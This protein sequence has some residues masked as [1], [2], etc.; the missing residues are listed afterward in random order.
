MDDFEKQLRHIE[1]R[2]DR[3]AG[4]GEINKKEF[5]RANR[6]ASREIVVATRSNLK[7]YKED[8]TIHFEDRDDIV[9][10]RVQLRVL[11]AYG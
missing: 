1:K 6:N 4:F 3:A 9:V 2:L 11:F 10:K 8:I 7:P 5:R